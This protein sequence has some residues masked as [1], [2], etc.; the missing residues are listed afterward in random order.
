M[1]GIIQ[2]R[3]GMGMGMGMGMRRSKRRQGRK[4]EEK[5]RCK[6]RGRKEAKGKEE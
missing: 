2:G 6:R 4:G 1:C 3:R 5:I